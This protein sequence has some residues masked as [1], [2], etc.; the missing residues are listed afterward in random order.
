MEGETIQNETMHV[1]CSVKGT[2]PYK[3]D[4]EAARTDPVMVGIV[5]RLGPL[6]NSMFSELDILEIPKKYDGHYKSAT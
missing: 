6:A 2:E 3:M 1:T 4:F 5:M